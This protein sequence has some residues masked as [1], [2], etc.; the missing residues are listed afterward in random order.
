LPVGKELRDKSEKRRE[1]VWLRHDYKR[2]ICT[3]HS[4]LFVFHFSL[5]RGTILQES[6]LAEK[7]LEFATQIVLIFQSYGKQHK[8]T[9]IMKQ[10]LRSGTSIGANINE[11]VFGNSKADFIAKLHIALKECS[12]SIYWLKI[13]KNT[14]LIDNAQGLIKLA[15]EIK[16][17]LISSLNTAKK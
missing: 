13:L 15:E 4:S 8:D 3:F 12:G 5:K 17:M 16:A 11:A 9:T 6:V 2:Q 7:S 14:Q 10:L 1:N